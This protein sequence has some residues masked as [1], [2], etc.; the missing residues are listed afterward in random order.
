MATET[1]LEM[2]VAEKLLEPIGQQT[3]TEDEKTIRFRIRNPGWKLSS[4]IFSK[5]AL[6]RLLSDP[7]REIKLE[8]L[9]RDIARQAK[10]R[11]EYRYPRQLVLESVGP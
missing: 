11:R 9:R 5:R 1:T 3:W 6:R 7:D 2:E 8:Y 4:I 10:C